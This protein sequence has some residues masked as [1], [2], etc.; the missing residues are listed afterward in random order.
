MSKQRMSSLDR[1]TIPIGLRTEPLVPEDNAVQPGGLNQC[2]TCVL[3][4]V[5]LYGLS[6]GTSVSGFKELLLHQRCRLQPHTHGTRFQAPF[7]TGKK[8]QG[9]AVG[10]QA[11]AAG[12]ICQRSLGGPPGRRT[13]REASN[14]KPMLE[15]DESRIV[16]GRGEAA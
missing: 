11:S 14:N 2:A 16:I 15:S 13:N 1:T 6:R 8:A 4:M 7:P 5:D 9:L 3:G 12:K 10:A